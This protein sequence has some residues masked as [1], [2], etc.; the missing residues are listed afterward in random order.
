MANERRKAQRRLCRT[1]P[2]GRPCD[3]CLLRHCS[4]PA[5]LGLDPH[6]SDLHR[7]F[8]TRVFPTRV[9]PTRVFP[10]RMFPTRMFPTRAFRTRMFPT[11]AFRTRGFA[12]D[13]HRRY[14]S[15]S[16]KIVNRRCDNVARKQL[17]ERRREVPGDAFVSITNCVAVV[18]V[19]LKSSIDYRR[20]R[21]GRRIRRQRGK[22]ISES[23]NQHG[24][25]HSIE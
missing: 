2:V 9:F 11:R 23:I 3:C 5:S 6:I 13:A 12:A 25:N 7:M 10:T 14:L 20:R 18:N 16:A 8:P 22:K 1:V 4:R 17:G 21:R 19:G 15:D 24:S